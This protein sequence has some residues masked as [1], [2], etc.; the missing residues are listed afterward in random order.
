MSKE[1]FE[2]GLAA[3]EDHHV[4]PQSLGGTK[5]VPLCGTCHERVHQAGWRRRDN[6]AELTREGLK[7]A[8]E[9]GVVLGNVTSLDKA[10]IIGRE[11]QAREA[12]EFAMTIYPIILPLKEQGM[13]LVQIAEYLNSNNIASAR[14]LKW[15]KSSVSNIWIRATKVLE[16]N[17]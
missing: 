10:R 3:T 6:H 15:G 17:G 4:I 16:R 13:T 7:R 11:T 9:R 1:C 14:G 5:T 12:D 8:K 2:C